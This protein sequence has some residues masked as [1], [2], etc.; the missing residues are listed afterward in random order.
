MPASC[1]CLGPATQLL[2]DLGA[3][4][5][6][7]LDHRDA[8]DHSL[9]GTGAVR[10][11][12]AVEHGGVIT[13][14]AVGES[15]QVG[16]GRGQLPSEPVRYTQVVTTAVVELDVDTA[17]EGHRWR[18]ATRFVRLRTDLRAADVP[19][20]SLALRRK[21]V[22]ERCYGPPRRSSERTGEGRPVGRGQAAGQHAGRA[23]VIFFDVTDVLETDPGQQGQ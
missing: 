22:S 7:P 11:G 17:F 2:P 8:V 20:P 5:H 14:H 3:A 19:P 12:Q 4:V 10:Q 16:F 21:T 1:K 13:A 18:H 9:H 23:A 6:L 15:V